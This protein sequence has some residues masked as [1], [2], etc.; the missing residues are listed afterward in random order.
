MPKGQGHLL[1]IPEPHNPL[2]TVGFEGPSRDWGTLVCE[3]FEFFLHVPGMR[4]SKFW[5]GPPKNKSQA[6]G[7]AGP[8]GLGAAVLLI[9]ACLHLPEHPLPARPWASPELNPPWPLGQY[10]TGKVCVPNL[11]WG[12]RRTWPL[13][14]G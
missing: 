10:I 2:G 4:Q 11:L 9:L 7:S 14:L 1:Q 6:R 3:H 12:L 5:K 8:L 13:V